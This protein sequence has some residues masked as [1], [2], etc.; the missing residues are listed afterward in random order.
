MVTNYYFIITGGDCPKGFVRKDNNCYGCSEE[1]YDSSHSDTAC[2]DFYQ[3]ERAPWSLV[4]NQLSF[5]QV[6][7]THRLER[8]LCKRA[9]IFELADYKKC[10]GLFFFKYFFWCA[11]VGYL[12][13]SLIFIGLYVIASIPYIHPVYGAGVRTQDLLIMSCLP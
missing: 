13:F 3:S 6:H 5:A 12:Y 9:K 10:L 8:T 4:C 11:P 7:L 1:S 2:N